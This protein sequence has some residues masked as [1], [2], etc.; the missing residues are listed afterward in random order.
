LVVIK[1]KGI[2]QGLKFN[3]KK[4]PFFLRKKKNKKKK[5]KNKKKKK[6]KKNVDCLFSCYQDLKINLLIS[7]TWMQFCFTLPTAS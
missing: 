2:F 4:I 6:K 3:F 5:K 1:I 7:S